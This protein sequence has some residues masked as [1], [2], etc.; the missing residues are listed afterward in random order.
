MNAAI[1]LYTLRHLDEPLPK[2]I[3]RVGETAFDG[4]EFAG[5]GDPS[6]DEIGSALAATTL[7]PM[8]AHV[9]VD[10]L[11]SDLAGTVEPYRDLGCDHLVVPWLDPAD[12]ASR[13]DVAETAHRLASLGDRL[14]DRGFDFSYHNHVHEFR[15]VD[16]T[17]AYE[18]LAAETTDLT[19]ELDAGWAL[20]GGHDPATLV[21]DLGER[22]PLVHFK[23][24]AVGANR[25]TGADPSYATD[26]HRPVELGDGDLDL[27]AVATAARDVGV[28]WACYE[29]DSPGDPVASLRHGS[30]VLAR[31]V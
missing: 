28:E 10:D 9:P 21:R 26:D 12:F 16:G 6:N 20:A 7:E 24:V 22:V 5:L 11:E 19:F 31:L 8:A 4:V 27:E 30:D 14:R 17:S 23:D 29:H 18:L 2:T 13:E 25:A 1:Q 15:P 3:D